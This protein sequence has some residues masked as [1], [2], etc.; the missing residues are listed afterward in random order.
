[1]KLIRTL[2]EYISDEISD[3]RK[4]ARLAADLKA[5]H[6]TLAQVLYNISTQEDGHQA[7][8]HNEVVKIIEEYKRN[9][10]EPSPVMKA[11]YD[12]E[13]QKH[14]DDLAEARMYQEVYKKA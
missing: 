6:P 5:E 3:I 12:H 8:L 13:H 7:S 9:H 10:G 14:I 4:Y 2:E 11:M 1:M